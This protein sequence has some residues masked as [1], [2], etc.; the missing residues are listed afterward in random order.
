MRPTSVAE[1]N[2]AREVRLAMLAN[3][4]DA[5]E[6]DGEIWFFPGNNG[7]LGNLMV[8]DEVVASIRTY[9]ERHDG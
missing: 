5:A 2:I 4:L 9:T 7:D 3:A 1:L 6:T 8:G